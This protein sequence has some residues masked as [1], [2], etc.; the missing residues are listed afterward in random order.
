MFRGK[1]HEDQPLAKDVRSTQEADIIF[2]NG[3]NL[4]TG[5]NGWFT[6]LMKNGQK[7]E[8]KDYFA[9][10][11]GV[12]IIYL[13]GDGHGKKTPNAWLNIENG[14]IYAQNIAKTLMAKDP[15]N[16]ETYRHNLAEYEQKLTCFR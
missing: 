10:S 6:K 12:D 9:V 14:I 11:D 4:E 8:N 15:A 5:G 16:K 1:S 2:Y 7:K 3:L 13:E